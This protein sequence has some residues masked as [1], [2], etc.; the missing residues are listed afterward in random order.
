M[1]T[2][3]VGSAGGDP[4]PAEY[5]ARNN[6][7]GPVPG[8]AGAERLQVSAKAGTQQARLVRLG[9]RQGDDAVGIEAAI[10]EQ[11]ANG[12][13]VLVADG[14][15]RLAGANRV[16]KV[17]MGTGQARRVRTGKFVGFYVCGRASRNIGARGGAEVELACGQLGQ[18]LL[19]QRKGIAL[20]SNNDRGVSGQGLGIDGCNKDRGRT[21]I[22]HR[23][24]A[25]GAATQRGPLPRL[26]QGL[27]HL[28]GAETY[29]VLSRV[30]LEGLRLVAVDVDDHRLQNPTSATVN[31]RDC[32]GSGGGK[33]HTGSLLAAEQCLSQLDPV[34]HLH[35]HG[36]LHA[37]VIEPDQRHRT[38]CGGVKNYLLGLTGNRYFQ[39]P[40]KLD[41]SKCLCNVIVKNWA[42]RHPRK[43]R[44]LYGITQP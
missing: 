22:G 5:R 14:P 32:S 23:H 38:R 29:S 19:A 2:P 42:R 18:Q 12:Y 28:V 41:H 1:V 7:V 44:A 24:L 3:Q 11:A 8:L 40:L 27:A 31:C 26:N 25:E 13:N 10:K 17:D 16:E 34:S 39:P 36:G 9:T 15:D 43:P 35:F 33:A 21:G 20:L 6:A 30:A 4:A 37:Y